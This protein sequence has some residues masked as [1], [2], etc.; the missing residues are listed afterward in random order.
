MKTPF[1]NR[2]DQLSASKQSEEH[3]LPFCRRAQK[4]CSS[5]EGQGSLIDEIQTGFASLISAQKYVVRRI[6]HAKIMPHAFA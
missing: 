3:C 1:M 2:E 4:R 6:G 5:Q